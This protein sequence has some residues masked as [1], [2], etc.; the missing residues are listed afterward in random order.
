MQA[1]N[2]RFQNARA[3]QIPLVDNPFSTYNYK[4]VVTETQPKDAKNEAIWGLVRMGLSTEAAKMYGDVV[5]SKTTRY[6]R[7]SEGG[8]ADVNT[9]LWG[10]S[11]YLGTGDGIMFNVKQN[12]ELTRGFD[13]SLRG[14]KTRYLI[15][16]KSF[17]PLTW[18]MIDVPLAAATT[19]FIAG[20]DT[21]QETAYH[22]P[23]V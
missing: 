12:N 2:V 11:P 8:F 17:I 19:K 5:V 14:T 1:E 16:D 18:S 13:S 6:C 7:K 22:N 3:N 9:Q 15:D 21:R 23:P 10:T 4:Y 20:S